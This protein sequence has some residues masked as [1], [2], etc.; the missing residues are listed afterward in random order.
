M[1][2]STL[3]ARLGS[4]FAPALRPAATPRAV[5]PSIDADETIRRALL[6]RLEREPW[7]DAS[8]SNVFVD[9]GTVVYQGLL[10]NADGRRRAR[11]A[12]LELP[13]VRDVWD[14]RVPR[15]EWQAMA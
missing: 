5:A 8:T 15:R 14:A 6:T 4:P 1:Q 2:S 10:K 9:R 7:W 12:A 11:Q 13:G 3:F